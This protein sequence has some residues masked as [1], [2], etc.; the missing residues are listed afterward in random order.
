MSAFASPQMLIEALSV[1]SAAAISYGSTNFDNMVVLSAYG[2]RPGYHPSF[3]RLTFV[4]V[5]VTVLAV[6]LALARAA[7]ALPAENI[8][9]LGLIPIGLGGYQLMQL[10][11]SQL[12]MSRAGRADELIGEPRGP[13]GLYAYLGFATVLLA[14]SSDSV[15]VLTPLFA[16]L[17]PAFVPACF[18]AAM[19]VA[20]LMSALAALLARHPVSRSLLEKMA[21]WILPFLLIAIGALI[22]TDRPADIFVG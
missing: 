11:V 3:V 2:A 9:Y 12:G 15:S 5:C 8:R 18:I 7:D 13:I 1:A 22:L 10:I 19:A 17:K 21:K 4:L 16:D 6:S 14:N 20:I